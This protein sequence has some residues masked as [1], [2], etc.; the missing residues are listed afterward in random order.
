MAF[1]RV[2]GVVLHHQLS[3]P[4]DRPVLVFSNSL[5]TD[6]RIWDKVAGAL[7]DRWRIL[8]YDNR[9]HGLSDAPPAPY[10]LDDHVDDLAALLAHLG[11]QKAAIVGLSVGGQIAQ[12]L[13]ARRPDLVTALVLCCTG[14]R[15]GTDEFW[16][17]RIEA[18]SG[19]G[20]ASIA[21]VMMQRWF[22][23]A[24]RSPDNPDYAGYLNMLVRTPVEGYLGT[25][26]ALRAADLT[27]STS[28]LAIPA[29]CIAGDQDGST[30]PE[31]VRSMSAL[32]KGAEFRII[33]DAGH[34]PCV[35]QPQAVADL[36]GSFLVRSKHV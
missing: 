21:D 30:P 17:A 23:P 13:A 28:A 36:I 19:Q 6:F 16:K 35:E 32:I 8:R 11:I 1:A 3:G 33:A 2:N 26:A 9:G 12:S 10:R 15:I 7:G 24:F 25:C 18:V 4:A 27:V 34:I 14:H 31:L 5:G 22:T 29:L 20:I